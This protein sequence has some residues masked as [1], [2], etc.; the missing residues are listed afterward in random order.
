M[1]VR[2]PTVRVASH[3]SMR[4]DVYQMYS[5][6]CFFFFISA[7]TCSS[8]Y[9]PCVKER[10]CIAWHSGFQYLPVVRVTSSVSS[11]GGV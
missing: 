3:V 7:F 4:G 10:R 9:F 2:S 1:F 8:S 5:F 6:F 11:R